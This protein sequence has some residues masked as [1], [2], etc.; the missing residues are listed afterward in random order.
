MDTSVGE[1]LPTDRKIVDATFDVAITAT[2]KNEQ[3]LQTY[4]EHPKHKQVVEKKLKPLIG[5][6]IAYDFISK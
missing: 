4:L 5:R 3:A 1:V 6:V 2:L